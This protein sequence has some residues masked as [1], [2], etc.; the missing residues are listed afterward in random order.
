MKRPNAKV[1]KATALVYKF[2]VNFDTEAQRKKNPSQY[3]YWRRC[4]KSFLG[5]TERNIPDAT[6]LVRLRLSICDNA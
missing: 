4:A 5:V 6:L 1:R 2:Q 3:K